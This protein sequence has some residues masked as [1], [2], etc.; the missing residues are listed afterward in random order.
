M[1][2][3]NTPFHLLQGKNCK[4]ALENHDWVSSKLSSWI[5]Q[6][7]LKKIPRSKARIISGISVNRKFDHE[8]RSYKLRLCFDGH[9]YKRHLVYDSVKLPTYD[10]VASFLEE[11][12][13]IG[14][15]DFSN[16]YVSS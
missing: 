13:A 2:E 7:F 1:W 10:Y 4:S 9:K 11:G 16:Y 5:D 8:S 6:G 14:T 3:P 12:D 15:M